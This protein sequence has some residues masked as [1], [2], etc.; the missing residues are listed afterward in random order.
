MKNLKKSILIL[1]SLII[2][3]LCSACSKENNYPI[4]SEIDLNGEK[5]LL[6][7]T[8]Y[9]T[10]GLGETS[11]PTQIKFTSFDSTGNIAFYSSSSSSTIDKSE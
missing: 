6:N 3:V 1:S 7:F 10:K 4:Y 2:M 9:I 5:H 11:T 8:P